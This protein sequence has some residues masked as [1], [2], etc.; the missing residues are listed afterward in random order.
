MKEA[1]AALEARLQALA[2]ANRRL[3]ESHSSATRLDEIVRL[4]LTPFTDRTT[5]EGPKVMLDPL[6][7]Q[8]ISLAL[9]ELATNAAKYGAFSVERGKVAVSW[10]VANKG[11]YNALTFRWR[12]SE[13]PP[14]VAPKHKGFG[15]TL[16]K[17][18]GAEIRLQFART[19]LS[20][21][22][23]MP[24]G[25]AEPSSMSGPA[26]GDVAALIGP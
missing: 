19:G 21:E 10:S 5:I 11:K 8:N 23:D 2:R 1:R 4:E 12:E 22:I 24:L 15:T 20:C 18:V 7:A 25:E 3:T 13:G 16:L 17:A 9:H 26:T 6:H 14:V